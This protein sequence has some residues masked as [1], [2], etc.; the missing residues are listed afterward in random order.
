MSYEKV[1]SIKITDKVEVKSACNNVRPLT[2]NWWEC[3]SLT[4]ILKEK[5][6]RAVE[7]E[8]FKTFE[9]GT[10]QAVTQN[11]YRRALDLMYNMF[12]EEYKQFSWRLNNAKY[13]SKEAQEHRELRE[14]QEFK[15]FLWKVL[16]TK[17]PKKNLIGFDKDRNYYIYKITTRQI[18]YTQSKEQ[19]KKFMYEQD[20]LK[21]NDRGFNFEVIRS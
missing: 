3:V 1:K 6:K 2:Y 9:E 17:L 18:R 13:G 19:A 10:F 21:Y 12:Y 14:S 15:D 8:I 5:G 16:N 20:I 4:K 7:I 11:R